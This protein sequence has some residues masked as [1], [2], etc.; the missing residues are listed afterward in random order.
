MWL[1]ILVGSVV[2]CVLLGT[3]V[4]L[5]LWLFFAPP[6]PLSPEEREYLRQS[7]DCSASSA[8]GGVD[9][10]EGFLDRWQLEQ[11]ESHPP[12]QVLRMACSALGY[13]DLTTVSAY[14][15]PEHQ[16]WPDARDITCPKTLRSLHYSKE[17]R[18][19]YVLD[20]S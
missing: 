13:R 17:R 6:R 4:V 12:I 1:A 7:V 16:R 10:A 8:F 20:Q 9:V 19:F 11:Q 5:G 2:A 3:W 14:R 18:E 15:V